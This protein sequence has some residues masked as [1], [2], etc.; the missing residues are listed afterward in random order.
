MNTILKIRRPVVLFRGVF[1]ILSAAMVIASGAA[2]ALDA[3]SFLGVWHSGPMHLHVHHPDG[4]HAGES[5]GTIE[6]TETHNGLVHA[7]AT[8]QI[9]DD[10]KGKADHAG[11][12]VR[13][14][15][16][17]LVGVLNFDNISGQLLDTEDNGT[18]HVRLVDEDHMQVVYVEQGDHEAT[19]FRTV[20]VRHRDD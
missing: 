11:V 4:A 7:V 5:S 17:K 1:V 20:L 8:W 18:F 12:I 14:A 13:T 6:I 19:L 16:S 10:H 15:K 2:H 9:S 3:K